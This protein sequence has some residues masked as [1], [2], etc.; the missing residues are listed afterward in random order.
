MFLALSIAIGADDDLPLRSEWDERLMNAEIRDVS[1]D[2]SSFEDA[3]KEIAVKLL[4]RCNVYCD[5]RL[6][7]DSGKF[8]LHRNAVKGRE[9]FD[10]F[11]AAYPSYTLTQ[12][13]E[14]RLI[15]IH[16]KTIN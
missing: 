4:L 12:D 1:I 5:E 3:W 6:G 13:S 11:L 14:T 16:P 8:V 10:A 2:V 9:L 15:W 7:A